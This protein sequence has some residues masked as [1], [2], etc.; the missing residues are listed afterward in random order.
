MNT[1]VRWVIY[2]KWENGVRV[3]LDAIG[4]FFVF[5]H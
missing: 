1:A 5:F 3:V 2:Y 4:P